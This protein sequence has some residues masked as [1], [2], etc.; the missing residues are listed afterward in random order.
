MQS[1]IPGN[2]QHEA[3]RNGNSIQ[4]QWHKNKLNLINYLN[5]L[6]QNDI[7]LD[8]GCG[9]GNTIIEFAK[10]VQYFVG[11]DWNEESIEFLKKKIKNFQIKNV[12]V[13]DLDLLE[14]SNLKMKFSRIIMTEVIEHLTEDDLEK[15]LRQ[16]HEIINPESRILITTPNYRSLWQSIETILD[17]FRLVPKLEGE[18]HIVKYN[19]KKLSEIAKRAKYRIIAKGT[20]NWVSP[21][22]ASF[23]PKIADKISYSEFSK[24]MIGN[25]LYVVLGRKSP[26]STMFNLR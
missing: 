9:S 11:V 20:L 1:K 14:I 17:T 13:K 25:L 18:Q 3:L 10:K 2:Y 6:N 15:V 22:L 21:F 8:A 24:G 16:M 12:L 19:W 26:G 5:F 4:R 23:T 7:V